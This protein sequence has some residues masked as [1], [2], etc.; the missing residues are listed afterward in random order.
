[1][2][3]FDILKADS[4]G[5][6]TKGLKKLLKK[7]YHK[8]LTLVDW[9][10]GSRN[11]KLKIRS[12]ITDNEIILIASISPKD[13]GAWLNTQKKFMTRNFKEQKDED[14]TPYMDKNWRPEE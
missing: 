7:G 9:E 11:L 1:M 5:K 4:V 2:S 6:L 13:S 12:N 8:R 3:W 14:I 10:Q